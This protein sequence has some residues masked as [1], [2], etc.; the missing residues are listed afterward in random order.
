[1]AGNKF[2][3]AL[4]KLRRLPLDEA[5]PQTPDIRTRQVTILHFDGRQ[6][7]TV[8]GVQVRAVAAGLLRRGGAGLGASSTLL[9]RLHPHHTQPHNLNPT[10]TFPG[11]PQV[12]K[13]ATLK[14]IKKAAAPLAGLDAAS[15]CFVAAN[16]SAGALNAAFLMHDNFQVGGRAVGAR[17]G[18]CWRAGRRAGGGLPQHATSCLPTSFPAPAPCPPACPLTVRSPTGRARTCG[19]CCGAC[20]S[21]P[22][23][24]L[25]A[26]GRASAAAATTPPTPVSAA[27]DVDHAP[28]V[29]CCSAARP[30]RLHTLTP[31]HLTPPHPALPPHLPRLQSC[32]TASPRA[33]PTLSG[34]LPACPRCCPWAPPLPTVRA[35]LWAAAAGALLEVPPWGR[36]A[37]RQAGPGRRRVLSA[38]PTPQPLIHLPTNSLT[39]PR[40]QD[41]GA[42]G[43]GAGARGA[44]AA[45]AAG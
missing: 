35:P 7:P 4:L 21:R 30:I 17:A 40:R 19:W 11:H 1:M 12:S 5:A 44:G 10:H 14:D 25:A 24:S 32:S 36:L 16:L 39:L 3:P 37:G 20:P 6:A 9:S 34:S 18:G 13:D 27:C 31:R 8:Y 45:A 43:A 29:P 15:E 41:R 33:S 23:T 28:A 42:R 38:H 2:A 26:A 22:A